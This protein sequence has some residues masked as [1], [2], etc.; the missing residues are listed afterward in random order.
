M[1]NLERYL[2]Q[3]IEQKAVVVEPPREVPVEHTPNIFAGMLRRWYIAVLVL[4]VVSAAGLPSIWLLVKPKCVVAGAIRVAP[5]LPNILTGDADRGSNYGYLMNTQAIM[6]TSSRVLQRVADDLVG[7]DLS[8]FKNDS[9]SLLRRIQS[10]LGVAQAASDAVSLL[11]DA[12]ARGDISIQVPRNTELINVTMK[13]TNQNEAKQIVD[14]FI[15]NYMAVYV[16]G[17]AREEDERLTL[18]ENERKVLSD[19]LQRYR[20]D[21]RKAASEYGATTLEGRQ[22]MMLQR[23][24]TLLGELTKLEAARISLEANLGFLNQA[25]Q[26]EVS[27]ERLVSAR[28]EYVNSD[29]M[30]QELTR[31]IIQ[32]ERDLIVAKQILAPTHPSLKTKREL[33]DAFKTTLDNKRQEAA[34]GFDEGFTQRAAAANQERIQTVHSQIDQIKAQES[35]LREVLNQQDTEARQVGRAHLTMQDLQFQYDLDKELYDTVCRRIREV[36]ME[37]KRPARITVANP[38][39]FIRMEDKRMKYSAALLFGA[40]GCGCL[41]AFLRDKA[42]QSLRTPED[43]TRRIGL[44]LIGTTTSSHSIKPALF[45]EQVA[46][47]YQVIRANLGLL[48]SEGMPRKVAVIS[49]GMRE[50]KT[51]FAVNLATSMAKSGKRVLLIDGDLRKPDVARMLGIADGSAGLVEVLSGRN[52]AQIIQSV[53]SSGLDVLLGSPH[54]VADVYELLSSPTALVQIDRLANRYDHVIVDTPPAL[55]FPDALMWAKNVDGVVLVSFAGQTNASELRETK[56]RLAKLRIR[57]LGTILGNVPVEH[58]YYHYGYHH[59][60]RYSRSPKAAKKSPRV[61]KNLLLPVESEKQSVGDK[62]A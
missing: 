53:P 61:T 47:D 59:Y 48:N 42:D 56:E 60:S 58:S 55:A 9:T 7:R 24:T 1:S 57:I 31:N 5:N 37:R 51:T 20:D 12:I 49:P 29:P 10:R 46:S 45:A 33:L 6:F 2:D 23:V 19:K 11:T 28:N 36:E 50:G 62:K 54:Q 13:S 4:V 18:L 30:V 14:A 3:V 38:A 15:R 16:S 35:R 52:S 44:V 27:P 40:F 43:V 25:E 21:I 26:P 22:D 39:G 32:A 34:K 17:A 8:F 41:L